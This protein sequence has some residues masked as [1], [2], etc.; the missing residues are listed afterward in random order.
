MRGPS[1]CRGKRSMK[2]CEDLR[3]ASEVEPTLGK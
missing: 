3:M 1:R 2:E